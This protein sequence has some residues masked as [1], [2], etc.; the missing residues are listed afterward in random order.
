MLSINTFTRNIKAKSENWDPEIG[1]ENDRDHEPIHFLS[2]EAQEELYEIFL[3][4][5]KWKEEKIA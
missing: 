5:Q 4:N 3:A 1:N 2:N